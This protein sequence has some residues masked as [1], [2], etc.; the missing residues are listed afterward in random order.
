MYEQ[1]EKSKENRGKSVANSIAQ[2]KSNVKQDF[3]FVDNRF[4]SVTQRKL[5]LGFD[6]SPM[7]YVKKNGKQQA[8]MPAKSKH[9]T[10]EKQ[11]SK[12]QR[13]FNAFQ[14]YRSDFFSSNNV[15]VGQVNQYFIEGNKLHG[16]GSSSGGKDSGENQATK[17][18]ANNFVGWWRKK[19]D[20]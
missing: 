5:E 6:N 18:D 16:H 14:S 3:G 17:D 1:V 12:A 2:K 9:G 19:Y 20:K 7:Q 10:K 4:G 15:T 11:Q 13:A 8:G